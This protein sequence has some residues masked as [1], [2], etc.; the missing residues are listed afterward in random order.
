MLTNVDEQ[1][2]T[3]ASRLKEGKKSLK[4]NPVK[5]DNGERT[6]TEFEITAPPDSF[7]GGLATYF[8]QKIKPFVSSLDYKEQPLLV[9]TEKTQ[10][11]FDADQETLI[12]EVLG[13]REALGCG[14]IVVKSALKKKTKTQPDRIEITVELTPDYQKDYEIIPYH[15]DPDQNR[16]EIEGV[17]AK[18][19]TKPFELTRREAP[20]CRRKLCLR[21]SGSVT[22]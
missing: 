19:I 9:T 4:L 22:G 14:K 3:F 17:M 1:G 6:L 20:H 11:S 15:R 5:L 13:Q 21:K 2:K 12:K 7:D 10:Y 16:A 8:E 18:Y